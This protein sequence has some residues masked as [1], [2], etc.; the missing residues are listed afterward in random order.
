[1]DWYCVLT[2]QLL[3]HAN[4]DNIANKDDMVNEEG[5]V[6][7]GETPKDLRNM[8][9][10]KVINLYKATLLYQMKSVCSYYKNVFKELS[11]QLLDLKGWDDAREDVVN[12][13]DSL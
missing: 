8:L 4:G 9:K 10:L 3:K 12:A 5:G 13:E 1:M 11:L 6:N 7:G 2:D